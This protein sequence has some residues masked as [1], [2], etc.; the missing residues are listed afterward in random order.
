[1]RKKDVELFSK[2]IHTLKALMQHLAD[3]RENY[4]KQVDLLTTQHDVRINNMLKEAKEV[5]DKV[6]ELYEDLYHN[7]NEGE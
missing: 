6:Y 3:E 4:H 5:L 7:G 2:A 1:M